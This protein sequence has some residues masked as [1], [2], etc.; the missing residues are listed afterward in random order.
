MLFFIHT[1]FAENY[2]FCETFAWNF[3]I[4]N[5]IF[6]SPLLACDD[7]EEEESLAE[8]GKEEQGEKQDQKSS[9]EDAGEERGEEKQQSAGQAE[10]APP[11]AE[12]QKKEEGEKLESQV[13]SRL[14]EWDCDFNV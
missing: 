9:T 12:S 11:K 1:F 2:L 13:S 7:Q 4:K 3:Y 10:T 5:T 8:T 14:K 6:L